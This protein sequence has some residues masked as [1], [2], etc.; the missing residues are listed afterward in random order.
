VFMRAGVL[1]GGPH[2]PGLPGRSGAATCGDQ[3]STGL[4]APTSL[5]GPDPLPPGGGP[6]PPRAA[7]AAG[8]GLA[9]PRARGRRTFVGL[10]PNYRIKC[11]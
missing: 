2:G 10:Q 9:L 8:A 3:S 4:T 11:G 6:A 1:S 5:G 7:S